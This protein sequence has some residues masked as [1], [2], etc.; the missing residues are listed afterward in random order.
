M[1]VDELTKL[2]A[3]KEAQLEQLQIEAYRVS[4][5]HRLLEQLLAEQ[6]PQP[7]DPTPAQPVHVPVAD[8]S[9]PATGGAEEAV[10]E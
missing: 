6:A 7:T 2:K 9:E 4:G 8:Q 5:E 1:T 10:S 3:D